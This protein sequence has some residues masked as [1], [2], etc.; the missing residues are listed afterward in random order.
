MADN[1]WISTAERLPKLYERVIIARVYSVG[2]PMRVE[3]GML[4]DGG[5]PETPGRNEE[6]G[7]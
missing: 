5:D 7:S 1:K 6:R 4:S 2:K 3:A